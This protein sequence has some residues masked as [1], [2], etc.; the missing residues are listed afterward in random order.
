MIEINDLEEYLKLDNT[1]T[2]FPRS[3][4]KQGDDHHQRHQ[5]VSSHAVASLPEHVE[6]QDKQDNDG[7]GKIERQTVALVGVSIQIGVDLTVA[8][9]LI[10]PNYD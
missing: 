7:N 3:P 10:E 2:Q 1:Q 8:V 5:G 4:G 9:E 6:L